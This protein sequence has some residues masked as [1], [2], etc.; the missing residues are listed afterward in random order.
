[1][2][3]LVSGCNR[4]GYV[5]ALLD[6]FKVEDRPT[7]SSFCEQRQKIHFSFFKDCFEELIEN[8]NKAFKRFKGLKVYAVDGFELHLPRTQDIL[9]NDYH[10]RRTYDHKTETYEPRMYTVQAIDVLNKVHKDFTES[11]A[12]DE[13]HYAKEF[14]KTFEKESLCIYDRLYPVKKIFDSHIKNGNYFLIRCRSKGVIKPIQ[15]F[16]KSRKKKD[17]FEYNGVTLRLI[18]VKVRTDEGLKENVF[19][20]NLPLNLFNKPTVFKLYQLRWEAENTFRDLNEVIQLEKWHSKTLN[21]IKQEIYT[22][23]WLY[24]YCR[25]QILKAVKKN[26]SNIAINSKYKLPNFKVL[27]HYLRVRIRDILGGAC[28]LNDL[29]IL[30]KQTEECR[31]RYSRSCERKLRSAA[32]PYKRENTV[33]DYDLEKP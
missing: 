16:F 1:M 13:A 28:F 2:V 3:S 6:S 8:K 27:Y 15:N 24:N 5:S 23:L 7:K 11:S 18:K 22:R 10:G 17:Q 4:Q 30:S 25:I 33:K 9:D 32:S 20:S 31:K 26:K 19:V 29:K 12:N 21:G 14:I